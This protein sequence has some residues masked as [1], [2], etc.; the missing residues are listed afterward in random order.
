MKIDIVKNRDKF[1]SILNSTLNKIN[2]EDINNF[3]EFLDNSDFFTAPATIR[4]CLS[5]DGGLCEYT[6]QVYDNLVELYNTFSNTIYS[7]ET[8]VKVGLLHSLYKINM[9]DK[10]LKNVKVNNEWV[11]EESYKISETKETYGNGGLTSYVIASRYLPLSD[12][13][14][15]ALCNY[16]RVRD[17]NFLEMNNLLS[18]NNLLLLLHCAN[19]ITMFSNINQ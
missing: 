18:N 15:V 13:E 8:L 16:D 10:Y 9:Y 17:N 19:M 2:Q 11:Q 4:Y 1:I 6:L 3:I 14:I 7:T 5:Q 12:E